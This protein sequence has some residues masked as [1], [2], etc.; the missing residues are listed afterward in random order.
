MGPAN[1]T[2]IARQQPAIRALWA[3][4][5]DQE[6]FP[7]PDTQSED[8]A[9]G[10]EWSNAWSTSHAFA[11]NSPRT[12]LATSWLHRTCL[13]LRQAAAGFPSGRSRGS[14]PPSATSIRGGCL[15]Q[16]HE[17]QAAGHRYPFASSEQ[18]RLLTNTSKRHPGGCWFLGRI[19]AALICPNQS[20]PGSWRHKLSV[21]RALQG[22]G[23]DK[24]DSLVMKG[25][26]VRIRASA[27]RCGGS[28]VKR[29]KPLGAT[30]WATIQ[31][32]WRSAYRRP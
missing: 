26:P 19:W 1:K 21:Y 7:Q 2:G 32:A 25:S 20:P 17:K 15:R 6:P 13:R 23:G 29:P 12:I 31:A 30:D 16:R 18:R 14:N 4:P 9:H 11:R 8:A 3:A 5:L 28:L 24:Y 27:S 10:S 22:T